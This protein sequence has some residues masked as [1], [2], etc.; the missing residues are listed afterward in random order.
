MIPFRYH[1]VTI[2]AVFL[3]LAVG[4]LA[5]SAFVDPALTNQ[6]RAQT[7]RLRGELNDRIGELEQ[8][9]TEAAQLRAFA[10][11][12]LQHLVADRLLGQ[13]VVVVT[14]EGVEGAVLD[15][16]QA[17]LDAAGANVVAVLTAR[18][19]LVADDPDTRSQLAEL[20]GEGA[21]GPTGVAAGAAEALADRLANGAVGVDPEEDLLNRLLSAG[22]LD[23]EVSEQTLQDIGVPGQVVVVLG[24]G[25]A[26]APALAPQAFALPLV[27]TLASLDVPVAA[28]ESLATP[29]EVSFVAEVRGDGTDG[30]VTV[31]DLD[32]SMG[33][34][35]LVLGL[36]ALVATGSGGAYGFRDDADPLPPQP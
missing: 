20:V 27:E 7:D 10:D 9:R 1:I 6:L 25:P 13:G 22:F 15:Q 31:D 28:G 16:T 35:A 21:T 14:Q 36:D 29:A 17:A 5:G 34:A 23:S 24:G 33:G 8:V 2:V 30:T 3:A 11:A 4:L 12:S 19:T 18:S 32:L 26:E